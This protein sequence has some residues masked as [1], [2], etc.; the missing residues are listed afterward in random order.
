MENK[1]G[2][3]FWGVLLGAIATAIAG[4]VYL[5]RSSRSSKI[6]VDFEEVPARGKTKPASGRGKTGA[7]RRVRRVSA[8]K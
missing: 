1:E 7:V 8:K 4:G 6:G 3:F 2:G 5:S